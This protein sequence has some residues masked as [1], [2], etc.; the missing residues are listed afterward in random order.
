MLLLLCQIQNNLK[1][2]PAQGRLSNADLI[3]LAGA[4]AVQICG[5]PSINVPIGRL[6]APQADPTG[7]MV[8]EKA[9]IDALISNFADKG[10]G[11]QELVVLSGAHT[12]GKS[13]AVT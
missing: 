13:E 5:G 7:R 2:T 8:S 12:L 3:A 10:L 9:G 4:Y 6:D 1:G 11:I